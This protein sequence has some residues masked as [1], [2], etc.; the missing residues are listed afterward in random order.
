MLRWWAPFLG[1]TGGALAILS[2]GPDRTAVWD[3]RELAFVV[4]LVLTVACAV[5]FVVK[6]VSTGAR[7]GLARRR[8][9][10]RSARSAGAS[11]PPRA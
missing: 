1:I 8:R 11:L 4:I 6:G 7:G 9:R 2:P 5:L 3:H 10:A